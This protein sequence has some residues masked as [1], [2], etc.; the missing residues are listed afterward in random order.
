MLDEVSS[1]DEDG[2]D[3]G[4]PFINDNAFANGRL[5]CNI[6]VN[7]IKRK[8]LLDGRTFGRPESVCH[9]R[10]SFECCALR[11]G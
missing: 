4:S 7:I 2:R 3:T 1:T 8:D 11:T 6:E 5:S 9:A 10:R